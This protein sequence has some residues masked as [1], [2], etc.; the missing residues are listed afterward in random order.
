[1]QDRATYQ[2]PWQYSTGMLDVIVNGVL[3]IQDGKLTEARPGR[4][5]RGP[6]FKKSS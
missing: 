4:A 1:V 2:N 3:V 5:L 6:G